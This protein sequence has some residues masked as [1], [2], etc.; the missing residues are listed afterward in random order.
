MDRVKL[1]DRLCRS[2]CDVPAMKRHK[3]C[4]R[5]A[6]AAQFNQLRQRHLML[7]TAEVSAE[8]EQCESAV[9]KHLIRAESV[10]GS[11]LFGNGNQGL[12]WLSAVLNAYVAAL[13]TSTLS[14]VFSN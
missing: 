6:L 2:Q 9:Q 4:Y 10:G 8:F 12:F 14:F 11:N 7:W 5:R 13:A 1:A 3:A